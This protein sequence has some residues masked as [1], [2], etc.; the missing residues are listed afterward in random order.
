MLRTYKSIKYCSVVQSL[1]TFLSGFNCGRLVHEAFTMA[2]F[3][4]DVP[5]ARA[6]QML[7]Y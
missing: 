3:L 1:T 2:A 6:L 7:D 4:S 5:G